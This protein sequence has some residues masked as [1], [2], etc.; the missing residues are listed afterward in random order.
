MSG[1][2]VYTANPQTAD[3][4]FTLPSAGTYIIE[5]QTESDRKTRKVIVK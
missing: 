5:A 4:S 2:L 1:R 3:H